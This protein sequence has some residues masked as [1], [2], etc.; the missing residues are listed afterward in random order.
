MKRAIVFLLLLAVSACSRGAEV[1]LLPNDELPAGLY[2]DQQDPTVEPRVVR[3]LVYFVR[4][5]SQGIIITP[6]RLGAVVREEETDLSSAEFVLRELLDR[7]TA[8]ERETGFFTAI[9]PGTVLLGVSVRGTVADVNLTAQFESAGAE[10][11]HLLRIAQVVWTLTELPE[12]DAV[13]FRIHGAPQPVVDQVGI[14]HEVVGRGRYSRLA[15]RDLEDPEVQTEAAEPEP[16]G[17]V[18]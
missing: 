17:A 18:P 15:P 13:R 5:T 10:V 1:T 9:P 2:G 11:L 14:A 16:T 3:A 4:A 8:Q 7:P 12:I 6:E